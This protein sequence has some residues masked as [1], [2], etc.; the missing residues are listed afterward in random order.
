M[1]SR[2]R[3]TRES[4]T[5]QIAL[6]LLKAGNK[7]F[8]SNLRINRDHLEMINITAEKQFP[9]AAIL[10]CSDSRTAAEFV[11]DQ[12]LGDI[13]SIRLAGNI[14]SR[15]AVG[16]MEYACKHLG[17]KL[18]VVLGH[19][20]CGAVRAAC[21]DFRLDNLNDLLD[22][23]R[24]AILSEKKT[25]KDRTANNKNFLKSVTNQNV[26]HNIEVVM[27]RSAILRQMMREKQIA[28]IGGVHD[29]E[30][31]KVQFLEKETA[32]IVDRYLN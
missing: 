13:F 10:S 5:P 11:F 23:I 6:A 18:I 7:R 15:N 16:S 1:T 9:F 3:E 4:M 21:D 17:S 12:G 8:I 22:H 2:Y 32:V 27:E 26:L 20:N 14:A 29:L 25:K 31:G 30:T 19:T 28:I 24:L